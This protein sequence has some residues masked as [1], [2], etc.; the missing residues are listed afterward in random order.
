MPMQILIKINRFIIFEKKNLDQ[1]GQEEF[2]SFIHKRIEGFIG[3][4]DEVGWCVHFLKHPKQLL[5]RPDR[6]AVVAICIKLSAFNP[7]LPKFC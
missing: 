2:F 4:R 6:A 7:C 5:N 1:H 3:D